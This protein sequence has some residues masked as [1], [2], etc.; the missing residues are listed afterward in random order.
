MMTTTAAPRGKALPQA[1][2]LI[3]HAE[4]HGWTVL[5]SWTPPGYRGAPILRVVIGRRVSPGGEFLFRL[6][7]SAD[8]TRPAKWRARTP[9]NPKWHNAPAVA[10]IRKV[11]EAN[12]ARKAGE[13]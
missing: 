6:C 4:E 11:I 2:E 10:N 12:S 9:K 8:G 3:A 1:T 13:S 5:E 7:W